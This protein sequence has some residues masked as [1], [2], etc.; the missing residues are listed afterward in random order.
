MQK[1]Q[2]NA[3][4]RV[5]ARQPAAAAATPS[6]D[7]TICARGPARTESTSHPLAP[8]IDV[9]TVYCLVD[10]DHVDAVSDG[11]A[12]GF[13]YARDGHPNAA[14]LAQK[15]A[16]LEGAEAGLVCAS[17]MGAIASIFLTL[18]S[19]NDHALISEG[20]YGRTSA[21]A[22]RQLGRWGISHDIFDP[23]DAGKI[24]SLLNSKTRL[25]FVET[26]SNPLLRVADLDSL[27]AVARE[28][29]IPLVVDNTF[30][31]LLCRPIERGASIV[32]HSVTKM[33]GG[34]S[35]LT[36]GVVVG[37]RPMVEQVQSLA[38]TLGQTGN[39]FESWLAL[40]GLSTL[41]LRMDRACRSA[42]EL[43]RRF[44]AHRQ[45]ARVIYP[46][47]PSHR[48]HAL[49]TRLL[50]GGFGAMASIDLGDRARA[51]SF[52]RALPSIPFAPSL[53]DVQTTL[54]HPATTS[55]RGQDAA[56]L[57]RQ[58]IT[59]GLIRLSIGL[60]DPDDLWREFQQALDASSAPSSE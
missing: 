35:D 29:R 3:Q 47:L 43:A 31:P 45:V 39:P 33:I 56:Q 53:G 5:S 48:D 51:A 46:G 22:T 16:R 1:E 41:S 42:L 9:S 49:A 40:R 19:Q 59:A 28:A 21:L 2:E 50:E 54:S 7:A 13:I 20:V 15:I 25:I 4:V 34:H 52:M 24:G 8:S 6:G 14:Q 23:S 30:A 55:H 57:A 58:G 60:E 37:G 11:A 38:S 12:K 36:L 32:V 17:G 27:A 18:L 44:E 10:L 26:I